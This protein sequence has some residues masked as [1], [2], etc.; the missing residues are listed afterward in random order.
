MGVDFN[1][2]LNIDFNLILSVLVPG[3][4]EK[5]KAFVVS[6]GEESEGSIVDRMEQEMNASRDYSSSPSDDEYDRQMA[7]REQTPPPPPSLK[8]LP[9]KKRVIHETD[10]VIYSLV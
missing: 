9:V 3:K 10:K 6:S 7:L 5:R 8:R 2:I 4:K 1:L